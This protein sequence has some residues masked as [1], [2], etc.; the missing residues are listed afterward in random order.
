MSVNSPDAMK[1]ALSIQP[2]KTSI[3][4]SATS[5]QQ[6]KEGIYNDSACGTQ[7]NH[8]TLTVG[9]GLEAGGLEYWIMK[10]SWGTGWGESGYIRIQI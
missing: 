5:F 3:R 10:N 2:L 1:A 7:H 4:A 8:A 6:Y 9:W